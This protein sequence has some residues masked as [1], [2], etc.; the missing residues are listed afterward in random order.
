MLPPISYRTFVAAPVDRVFKAVATADGWSGWFTEEA[1][2]DPFPGGEYVFRWG[3]F[4]ADRIDLELRGRVLTY[5]RPR[6]FGFEW[7]S[8]SDRTSVSILLERRDPGTVVAVE[9]RGYA[10][11]DEQLLACLDCAC[12]W[13]EALTLLKFYVEHGLT[14]GAVASP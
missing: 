7:Q 8:G 9:E 3:G 1:R 11:S 14:Y 6:A 4:G 12:G 2:I 13:A 5:E 10:A